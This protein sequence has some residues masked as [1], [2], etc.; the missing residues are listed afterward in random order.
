MSEANKW[1][2]YMCASDG[3]EVGLMKRREN[4]DKELHDLFLNDNEMEFVR[5]DD[6]YSYQATIDYYSSYWYLVCLCIECL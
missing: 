2:C 6:T 3:I 4:W 5:I 1:Q